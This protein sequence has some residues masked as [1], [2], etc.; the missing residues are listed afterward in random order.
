MVGLDVRACRARYSNFQA[1]QRRTCGSSGATKVSMPSLVKRTAKKD[2]QSACQPKTEE[3]LAN[4]SPPS[5][6]GSEAGVGHRWVVGG[7]EG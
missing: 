4:P 1:G 6:C 5:T 2:M 3:G 7:G